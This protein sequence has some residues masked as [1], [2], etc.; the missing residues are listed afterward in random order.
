MLVTG[1]NTLQLNVSSLGAGTYTVK[2]LCANG[3]ETA[4]TKFTKQ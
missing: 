4:I 2:M 3:C 1:D